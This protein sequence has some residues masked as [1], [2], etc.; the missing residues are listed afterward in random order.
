M[1]IELSRNEKLQNYR[2][3]LSIRLQFQHTTYLNKY[4]STFWQCLLL[5]CL[6]FF[7]E[8][9]K[10]VLSKHLW[11]AGPP[12]LA[13]YGSGLACLLSWLDMINA[14]WLSSMQ[15]EIL[16]QMEFI[17]FQGCPT[18]QAAFLPGHPA[19]YNQLLI[20][21]LLLVPECYFAWNVDVRVLK[22]YTHFSQ[23]AIFIDCNIFFL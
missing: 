13:F 23:N 17:I 12:G 1:I 5:P 9:P 22:F 21:P 3:I 18:K 14:G 8:I 20:Q 7:C 19:A 16:L 11:W 2:I 10:Y 4:W 6:F 15:S